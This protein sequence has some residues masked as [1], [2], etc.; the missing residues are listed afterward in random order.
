MLYNRNETDKYNDII[1]IGYTRIDWCDIEPEEGKY[2]WDIIDQKI[3][4]YKNKEKNIHLEFYVLV[5]L[6]KAN[7]LHLNGYLMQ[8]Q[9][10]IHITILI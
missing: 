1:S 4:R 7:M 3:D 6:V 9:N 8:G 10:I 2:N 5:V